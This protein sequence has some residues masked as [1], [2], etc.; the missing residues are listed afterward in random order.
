MSN[1][2]DYG[3]TA[4]KMAFIQLLNKAKRERWDK[5]NQR[6]ETNDSPAGCKLTAVGCTE[7]FN[8]TFN[9]MHNPPERNVGLSR[10]ERVERNNYQL[11]N[12]SMS[13][14]EIAEIL[15][16]EECD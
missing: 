10:A 2:S 11:I 16:R 3:K 4:R 5:I 7:R 1:D 6:F 13:M 14:D 9:E 8:N 12:E 15:N